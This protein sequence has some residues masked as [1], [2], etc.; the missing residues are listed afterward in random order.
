VP[1]NGHTAEAVD[2]RPSDDE[3][4]DLCPAAP[5]EAK[6]AVILAGGRGVRLR[7]YTTL[8]PKPLVPIGDE[9][10]IL[11]V[12]LRQLAA[13]GF[14]GATLAIGHLGQ[15]VRAYVG[16][17]SQW[18]IAVDYIDEPTPLGT[19]GPVVQLLDR[20][21]SKFVVTN[22][23][24][25]TDL[26][27]DDLLRSHS[28]QNTPLTVATY[29]RTVD[30]DFG[31]IEVS[32]RHISGFTEKPSLGYTVSMGA[33]ALSKSTLQRY[34]PGRPL[35]FDQLIKDLVLAGD[36][37]ASYGFSGYWLDIGRPDDYDR[38][39]AEFPSVKQH[40][41]AGLSVVTGDAIA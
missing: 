23:D 22:G 27:Y 18:G 2:T 13:A 31:V 26:D 28:E 1:A 9:H 41:L 12:V 38:A 14:T 24:I 32:G 7:P 21:P 8:V 19:L 37:P 4:L 17:G 3:I 34:Q 30:I 5:A 15:L 39:N 20:L 11:E 10:S 35:G 40:L 25:L 16:D 6:H 36:P 33:Y 29:S